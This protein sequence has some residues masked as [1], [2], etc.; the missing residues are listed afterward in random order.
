MTCLVNHAPRH[1]DPPAPTLFNLV[2]ARRA[3]LTRAVF[4][5]A[6]LTLAL[7]TLAL[8]T[9]GCGEGGPGSSPLTIAECQELG[10]SPLFDPE[11]ERPLET[12]CPSGL[13]FLGEFD[14]PFFGAEGGICCTS[15]GTAGGLPHGPEGEQSAA[16]DPE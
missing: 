1:R 13:H 4:A 8:V 7:L 9:L 10:G 3:M 11:D 14:E 5:R 15:D 12:S 16:V 2:S 6:V